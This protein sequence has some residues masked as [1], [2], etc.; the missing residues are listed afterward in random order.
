MTKEFRRTVPFLQSNDEGNL[1]TC[2][3]IIAT[4]RTRSAEA[5]GNARRPVLFARAGK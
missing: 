4:A 5:V 2:R 1:M 3:C